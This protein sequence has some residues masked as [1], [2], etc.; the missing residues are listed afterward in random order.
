MLKFSLSD[1]YALGAAAALVVQ[2]LLNVPWVTLVISIAGLAVGLW[3]ARRGEVRM[4]AV[5]A[6]AAFAVSLVLSIILL[7]R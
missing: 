4:A 6:L 2:I 5:A 7:L 3:V 1:K